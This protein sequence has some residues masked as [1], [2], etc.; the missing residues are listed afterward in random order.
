MCN[1]SWFVDTRQPVFMEKKGKNW[2]WRKLRVATVSSSDYLTLISVKSIYYRHCI[3]AV[4]DL[5]CGV[6]ICRKKN[7]INIWNSSRIFLS[8]LSCGIVGKS[9]ECLAILKV[10]LGC[11]TVLYQRTFLILGWNLGTPDIVV[12]NRECMEIRGE[13]LSKNWEFSNL[14]ESLRIL[15]NGRKCTFWIAMNG[16]KRLEMLGVSLAWD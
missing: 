1:D 4:T 3:C 12:K 6:Y 10:S 5:Y 15:G 9:R 16:W 7:S 14:W 11:W 13:C 2:E 8:G